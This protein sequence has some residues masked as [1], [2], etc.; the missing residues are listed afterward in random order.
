[1]K[2]IKEA[3]ELKGWSQT[4]LAEAIGS[5]Q[6]Q[7]ARYERPNSD[8]KSGVLVAVSEACGVSISWLLGLTD[9]PHES[10]AALSG[11][12]TADEWY[13]VHMFRDCTPRFQAMLMD[14]AASYRNSSKLPEEDSMSFDEEGA[15]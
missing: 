7:V 13:L 1:M 8:V 15:A 2:R 10:A 9:S 4:A 14:T 3:R 12:L 11:E 5:S 6:Q